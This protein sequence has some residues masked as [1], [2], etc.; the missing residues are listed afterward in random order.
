Q[1]GTRNSRPPAARAHLLA[2]HNHEETSAKGCEHPVPPACL[3]FAEI[4][5]SQ[6]NVSEDDG[7]QARV[8]ERLEL[9]IVG[10]AVHDELTEPEHDGCQ[11]NLDHFRE[12]HGDEIQR[13]REGTFMKN[14]LF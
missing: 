12:E 11:T 6:R 1:T 8:I 4:P 13:P 3:D 7:S 9:P 5:D 2:C 14:A 10:D